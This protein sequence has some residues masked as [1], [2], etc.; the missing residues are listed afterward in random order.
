MKI[1]IS[2]VYSNNNAGDAALLSV[3]LRDL[4]ETFNNPE[5]VIL[6]MDKVSDGETFDDTP[7]ENGFMYH[8]VNRYYNHAALRMF[9]SLSLIVSTLCSAVIYRLTGKH[10]PLPS[11]LRIIAAR[12]E[13]ADLIVPAGGGYIRGKAGLTNTLKFLFMIQPL[14]FGYI[15]GKPTI[16]YTQSIGPFGNRTQAL[17][18]AF[19]LKRIDGIMV[20]ES[21]SL[22]LLRKL[23]VSQK[24]F[25]SIDAGFLFSSDDKKDLRNELGASK[26]QMLIGITARNWLAPGKQ[27]SYEK[28]VAGFCDHLIERYHAMVLIIPQVTAERYGDD[29]RETG[30][31]IYQSIV[32]KNGVRV[33][34]ERYDPKNIKA[35]YDGLDYLIGARFHSV[36]F[37][38]TAGVPSI[39]I[40]YEHK[41]SG[42]MHDLG[43]DAWVIK[44]EDVTAEKLD[45]LFARLIDQQKDYR[46]HLAATLPTYVARAGEASMFMRQTYE[47]HIKQS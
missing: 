36:I 34:T 41:T 4:R 40:E 46:A 1:V 14:L 2:H 6:T 47:R 29:D 19:I 17:L 28:A 23:G 30:N 44:I 35:I 8:A 43:L 27:D 12:Y 22:E 7:L 16:S 45:I 37:A 10:I 20:R 18:A 25:S 42:I 31:H 24:V 15:I 33:L 11:H 39:A 38:L 5:I 26:G 21:T 9:Y 3:L 13:E 32:R